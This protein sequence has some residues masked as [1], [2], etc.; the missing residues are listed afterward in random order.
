MEGGREGGKEEGREGGKER[1]RKEWR[2]GEG[3]GVR[4]VISDTRL[5]TRTRHAVESFMIYSTN[6]D[7]H[8]VSLIG[9]FSLFCS[10]VLLLSYFLSSLF[11]LHL[12]DT[13]RYKI[14]LHPYVCNIH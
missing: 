9:F 2:E 12:S 5:S 3:E 14:M 8:N 4:Y 13:I 1:R 10:V 11:S 6:E 7:I